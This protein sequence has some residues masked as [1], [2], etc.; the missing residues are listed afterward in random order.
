MMRRMNAA[1]F[2]TFVKKADSLSTTWEN[3]LGT[4]DAVAWYGPQAYRCSIAAL[5]PT[6]EGHVQKITDEQAA[7]LI[8]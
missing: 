4:Y 5:D 2:D 1:D 8:G 6:A 3:S 7:K